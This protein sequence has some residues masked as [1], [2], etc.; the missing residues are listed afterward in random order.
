M[1]TNPFFRNVQVT[2]ESDTSKSIT[3]TVCGSGY[4]F[5]VKEDDWKKYLAKEGHVQDLFPYLSVDI[6][7]LL[8]SQICGSCYDTMFAE[9]DE[10]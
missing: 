3:C 8:I 1:S 9:D 7:E 10:V 6:R 2:N 4:R 5:T